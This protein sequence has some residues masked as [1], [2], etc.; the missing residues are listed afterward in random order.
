L[1][2]KNPRFIIFAAA[3]PHKIIKLLNE[4]KS[5]ENGCDGFISR[6]LLAAPKAIRL[7]LKDLVKIPIHCLK[8]H[9]IFSA[10]MVFNLSSKKEKKK[11]N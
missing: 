1:E 10:V 6:F 4:E 8:L 7:E 11:N 9:Q 5:L 2:L 3:H